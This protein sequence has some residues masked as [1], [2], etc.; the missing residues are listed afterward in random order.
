MEAT[1][2]F[3]KENGDLSH[4]PFKTNQ[5]LSSVSK[6]SLQVH[7]VKN[8]TL[9]K[10]QAL[11]KAL[12]NVN[13]Q[14][15]PNKSASTQVARKVKLVKQKFEKYPEIDTF[16]PYNPLDFETLDVPEEHKLSDRCLAGVPLLVLRD[17]AM[18]FE[19]LTSPVLSPMDNAPIDY[20][21]FETSSPL[22]EEIIDLPLLYLGP[23]LKMKG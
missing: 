23:L 2:W 20:D 17:D 8:F 21:C 12:G 11:R 16:I 22:I 13:Q 9:D 6:G 15:Q 5:G 3:G 19:A 4:L 7:K 18:K 10:P 1:M 14:V